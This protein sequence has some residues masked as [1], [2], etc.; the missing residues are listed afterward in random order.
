MLSSPL[1]S[2]PRQQARTYHPLK[3]AISLTLA[4]LLGCCSIAGAQHV[5]ASVQHYGPEQ[6]LP[7]REVNAIVQD[8]RDFMWFGTKLGLSRF[9]GATFTTYTREKNGLDFDDIQSIAQ[10]ADGL[11]W[12]MGPVGKSTITL[13]DPLTGVAT[14]FEKR[15]HQSRLMHPTGGKHFLLGSPD[16]SI[17]FVDYQPAKLNVYHPKTGLRTVALPQ[18]KALTLAAVTARHTVLVF[19]DQTRLVEVTMDGRVLHTYDHPKAIY[20]CVAQHQASAD[21]FYRST[22]SAGPSGPIDKLYKIDGAGHRQALSPAPI[23]SEKIHYPLVHRVNPSG[24]SWNGCQL[25][26][27]TG[28]VLVD[29][30][31]QLADG[32]IDDRSFF[33]DRNGGMWLGTSFGVYQTRISQHYFQRLFYQSGTGKRPAVRGITA[34]G[35]TLY[36]NL[37]NDLGLFASRRSGASAR[38]LPVKPKALISLSGKLNG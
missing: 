27:A 13:F 7:H 11:L 16:G 20:A 38:R 10:D 33:Q 30:T 26:D 3:K 5:A 14:S 1:A 25:H 19:A 28:R 36:T 15:F 32:L 17:V 23:E 21:F 34:V 29:I 8:R 2:Y 31:S 35:D 4:C 12:L 37:E 9:D 22:T 24:L 18:Y 6:G